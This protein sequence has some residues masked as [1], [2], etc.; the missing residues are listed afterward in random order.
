MPLSPWTERFLRI[1]GA[2]QV[3]THLLKQGHNED[4]ANMGGVAAGGLVLF[5]TV[6]LF[7]SFLYE[8]IREFFQNIWGY[9][10]ENPAEATGIAIF[11]TM[12]LLALLFRFLRHSHKQESD[13]KMQ[14]RRDRHKIEEKRE[15][16]KR[17]AT[18]NIEEILRFYLSEKFPEIEIKTVHMVDMV[19]RVRFVVRRFNTELGGKVDKNYELF[20]DTLFQDTLHILE[21]VFSLS[22][23]IPAVVVDAMMSFI[24][25]KAKYYDGNVLSVKAQ[26][27]VFEHARQKNYPPFKILTSFDLRYND[28]M[29]VKPLPED[30]SKTARVLERIKENAPK[31]DVRYES[32]KTKVDDGWEKPKVIEEPQ[33]IQET[34]RGKELSSMPL[35]QFQDLILSVLAKMSFEVQKVKKVP[36][37]TLQIQADF[38]HPVVGGSFLVLARQYPETSPVHA[39][40][41]RELDEVTREEACKRGVYIVTGG[42]TE[43]AKNISRKMAVDL[44]D[45]VKLSGLMEGPPYDGRWTF[46]VVDEKGV[47]TDLS[48]MPLLNFERE[49]DLFLK[50]MGFRMEKIR[51]VPGGAVVA[52]AE[53]PH[54]ITGGKFC[55]LGRQFPAE[56][57]VAAEL[58]SEMSHVM[59]S[60]FCYRGLL[61]V[62]ADYAMDAKAL[63]RFSNVELVDRNTWE[64]LR[65]QL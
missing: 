33:V 52:V 49:V 56:E 58:V 23:N 19:P 8:I 14:V 43:E 22:E 34:L 30:E 11:G 12:M 1:P 36:G 61:M 57:R 21:V 38:S 59:R 54:P 24:S 25:G 18:G 26:R 16:L 47:L 53:F 44:V 42:F 40:L 20:R 27:D 46:R 63:A 41:I 37:G 45:G 15:H 17:G 62:P 31:L 32:V 51:R 60:E 6:I 39:D 7:N 35:A 28:G 48:K 65:R 64:N 29:E 9:C 2:K 5:L 13:K 55:V 4:E 50:S 10:E 3:K